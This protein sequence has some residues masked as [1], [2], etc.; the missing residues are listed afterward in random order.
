MAERRKGVAARRAVMMAMMRAAV[1]R[2]AMSLFP[3]IL[4]QGLSS[5]LPGPA[6]LRASTQ[7]TRGGS[8]RWVTYLRLY[9]PCL[10]AHS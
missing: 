6:E 3:Q 5:G 7:L 1:M 9:L 2:A 8:I 10:V 4:E